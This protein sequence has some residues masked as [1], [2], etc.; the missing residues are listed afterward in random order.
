[1]LIKVKAVSICG[2]DIGAYRLPSISKRWNPPLVL[3]HEFSG[4][5]AAIGDGVK[6][7]KIGQRV[8]ANPIL[9]CG[10]CHYCNSGMINLC[11]HRNSLGTSI[12]DMPKDGAMQ[13]YMLIRD[14]AIVPLDDN[15]TFEQGALLEPLAV[16]YCASKCGSTGRG[17]RVC[18]IGA[19]P[20]GL[21]TVKFLKAFGA[22]QI[23]A[24]DILDDRLKKASEYGADEVINGRENVAD[25]VLKLTNGIGVDR[26]IICA[27]APDAVHNAFRMVRSGGNIVLV[28]LMHREITIDPMQIACRAVNILGSYMFTHE[29]NTVMSMLAEKKLNTDGIITSK[30]PFEKGEEVFKLLASKECKDIKI[31]LTMN[32]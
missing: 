24:S 9:Y 28:A 26:V 8:T 7:R 29:M 4:T 11:T 27:D 25:T 20:I 30:F 17:E 12:G 6:G 15:V 19:G 16:T 23:F 21:M 13:E 1:M 3:G 18:I 22:S 31:L 14:S 2:S 10:N 5:I 32:E